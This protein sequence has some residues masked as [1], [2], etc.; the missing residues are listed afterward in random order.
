MF[1]LDFLIQ[2]WTLQPKLARGHS[3]PAALANGLVEC[4]TRRGSPRGLHDLFLGSVE[5]LWEVFY[6]MQ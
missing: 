2:I 3:T 4:K 6:A 1:F 5:N